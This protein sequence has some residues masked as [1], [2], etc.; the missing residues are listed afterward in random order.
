[1]VVPSAYIT[2]LKRKVHKCF[3]MHKRKFVRLG[4]ERKR[5]QTNSFYITY[6]TWSYFR[7]RANDHYWD[8]PHKRKGILRIIYIR[9]PETKRRS[10][11]ACHDTPTKCQNRELSSW[12]SSSISPTHHHH[13]QHHHPNIFLFEFVIC[14]QNKIIYHFIGNW[15]FSFPLAIIYTRNQL[16]S[17]N[18]NNNNFFGIGLHLI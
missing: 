16:L 9:T 12:L 7:T 5:K 4:Y 13:H 17:N 14:R 15:Q 6:C 2:K 18:N 10:N 3:V 8:P 11:R 1:M